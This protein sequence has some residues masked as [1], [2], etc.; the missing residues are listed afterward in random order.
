MSIITNVSNSSN[1]LSEFW[2]LENLGIEAG[3]SNDESIDRDTTFEFEPRI[4]YQNKRHKVI[5]PCNPNVK[6]LLEKNEQVQ[7]KRFMKLRSPFKSDHS[8]YDEN[9]LGLKN[10][11]SENSK[12]RVQVDEENLKQ[13]S[14]T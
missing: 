6:V 4:S 12:K 14:T 13:I 11:L 9:S 1:Q 10:Y 2:N 7:K 8:L 3:V 5:F